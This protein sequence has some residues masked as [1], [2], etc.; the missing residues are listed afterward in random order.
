M[1]DK[2]LIA[3]TRPKAREENIFYWEDYRVTVLQPR[4]FRIEQNKEQKFRDGA[5][6]TVWFRDMP[7]QQARFEQ[8]RGSAVIETEE[9]RLILRPA[10][11]DC[12]ILLGGKMRKIDNRG[13]LLGT[14]R[15]LDGFDGDYNRNTQERTK[16]GMGVCSKTGIALFDDAAS[17]TLGEDGEVK[18][19]RGLGTDE[20]VF[21]YGRDFRAAV[22]ALYL[23]TGD[24]P[25]LPRYALGNW[26]SRYHI[27][28]A[29][30][31]LTL[32]DRFRRER[33]P[34][35]VA[36]VDMD[37]HYSCF[38]E[39]E[40]GIPEGEKVAGV[41]GGDM[42]GWTGYTW[43]RN[44]FPDYRAFLRDVNG[45]G[46]KVTLN[47]HPA[48]GV[49]AWEEAYPAM[50]AALGREADG[51]P[52]SFDIADPDFL[53]AYF[54]VLHKPYERDGVGFWWIDWQQGTQS[55]IEGLD[56][57][58]SLNHYHYLDSALNHERPL[59]LSRYGGIGSHRYPVGFSGDTFTTWETLGFLPY[60]TATA[61]N[62][63]YTWWSHDIGGHVG[64]EMSGEL[65]ARFVQLGVF[66]PINRLHCCNFEVMTKEP[67]AY[68]NGTGLIAAEYLRFRHRLIPYLYT[69]AYRTHREG[70]ALVEPVYYRCGGQKNAYRYPR[71]FFFGSELFV[72]PVTRRR[73]RDGFARVPLW[74][75]EG[76]WTDLFTEDEYDIPA[77]GAEKVLLRELEEFPVFAGRGAILPLSDDEGDGALNPVR[78]CVWVYAGDGSFTMY[79]DGAAGEFFTHFTAREEGKMQILEISSEGEGSVIPAERTIEVHFRNI[80]GGNAV[81]FVN[82]ERQTAEL[83]RGGC[84][85]VKFPFAAGAE[86][87]IELTREE[88]DGMKELLRRAREVLTRAEG[89]NDAKVRAW[90]ALN[91][92][93]NAEQY[94]EIVD[95]SALPECCKLRLK[96][97]LS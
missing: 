46:L 24:V 29:E 26:W 39:R 64:G 11:A 17:L 5:T 1:L 7:P 76:H 96:E 51:T 13:N 38:L 15:T 36:T 63:G 16:L 62:V 80:R 33:I 67:W 68:G 57:L 6:Q 50:C 81:L 53:N 3:K 49:R 86:Y 69:C 27:Y 14:Y 77:G 20:Y 90:I 32:L 75:P 12:R 42:L 18:P 30:E 87:R 22:K 83:I 97:T 93:E 47:L 45:R 40:L 88:R 79:E 95:G 71:N 48:C 31:Y 74:F 37:W 94:R 59:I 72:A 73:Q 25:M 85:T 52:V 54:K 4:L 21:A 78:L 9:C 35:A 8:R 89:S 60:F 91:A 10:R 2:H 56:P 84:V 55:A 66:S 43:N 92:A 70:L 44:L 41:V 65:Y 23:I 61:S 34:L 28:T 82:G 19:E 58:W